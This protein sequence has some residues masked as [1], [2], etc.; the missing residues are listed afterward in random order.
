[1]AIAKEL[2]L[3]REQLEEILLSER[4]TALWHM[5]QLQ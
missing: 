3:S 4:S 1:M 5:T 2:A